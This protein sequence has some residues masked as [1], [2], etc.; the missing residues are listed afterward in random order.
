[1]FPPACLN[2]MLYVPV[3]IMDQRYIHILIAIISVCLVCYLFLL[4]STRTY[5]QVN[6]PFVSMI[7]F[8]YFI[9]HS[10]WVHS[11]QVVVILP[12]NWQCHSFSPSKN[13]SQVNLNSPSPSYLLSF[14]LLCTRS[15]DST[16][17]GGFSA[18]K[19]KG[20]SL[21]QYDA[22]QIIKKVNNSTVWYDITKT[23]YDI[24]NMVTEAL[25][26]TNINS[27]QPPQCYSEAAGGKEPFLLRHAY[28]MPSQTCDTVQ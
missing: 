5:V 3:L 1:M 12:G 7:V 21:L 27:S 17:R 4:E 16:I 20:F 25:W 23:S 19:W 9:K 28:N 26:H 8:V 11:E 13:N 24:F 18:P 22:T 15:L 14:H 6:V 2:L 10:C